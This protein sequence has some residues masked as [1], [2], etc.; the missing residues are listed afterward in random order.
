M[1]T[2]PP[3]SSFGKSKVVPWQQAVVAFG[4]GII[5]GSSRCG[6]IVK[7][8]LSLT[9]KENLPYGPSLGFRCDWG[10]QYRFAKLI[11][12]YMNAE[13]VGN[14]PD[15]EGFEDVIARIKVNKD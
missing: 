4:S 6:T 10:T 14:L 8:Y 15:I 1:I 13:D 11:C 12:K 2:I 3:V 5:S 9:T 7:D